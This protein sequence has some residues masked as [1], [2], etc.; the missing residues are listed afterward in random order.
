[1]SGS[2]HSTWI[3]AKKA[4]ENEKNSEVE[5]NEAIKI[6]NTIYRELKSKHYIKKKTLQ[7]RKIRKSGKFNEVIPNNKFYNYDVMPLEQIYKVEEEIADDIFFPLTQEDIN[8]I[9]NELPSSATFDLK[10]IMLKQNDYEKHEVLPGI[11]S[12][13]ILGT[14]HIGRNSISLYGYKM[15]RNV[16]NFIEPLQFYLKV[17]AVGVLIHEIAHHYDF[18]LT[19]SRKG[20]YKDT[21]AFD[22]E[23]YAHY[24]ERDFFINR[25]CKF[26]ERKYSKEY[27]QFRN[28]MS[29]IGCLPLELKYFD[30]GLAKNPENYLLSNFFW[31]VYDTKDSIELNLILARDLYNVGEAEEAKKYTYYVLKIQPNNIQA[32]KLNKEILLLKEN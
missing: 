20:R 15:V 6:T 21:K 31:N 25:V 4:L 16:H 26:I 1:M 12:S 11:W 24:F 23:E 10:Q 7:L 13:T 18:T 19:Y 27:F 9:I 2:K 17:N 29:N 22:E 30:P 28:W 32:E 14:A 8:E 5:K 3:D